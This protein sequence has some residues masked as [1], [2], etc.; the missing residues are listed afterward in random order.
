MTPFLWPVTE[1]SFL[2]GIK[3]V[4]FVL[5]NYHFFMTD[6]ITFMTDIKI[7]ISK[8]KNFYDHFYDH[9]YDQLPLVMTKILIWSVIK[10]VYECVQ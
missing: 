3:M 5:R 8:N 6:I 2:S 4:I 9:F 10:R 1:I 7:A